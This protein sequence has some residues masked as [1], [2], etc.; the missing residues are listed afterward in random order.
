M[1]LLVGCRSLAQ[2]SSSA[3]MTDARDFR[4]WPRFGVMA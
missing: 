4:Y 2:A 1:S 3:L